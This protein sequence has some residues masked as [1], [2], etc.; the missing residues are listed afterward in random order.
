MMIGS[1]R[2]YRSANRRPHKWSFLKYV[3]KNLLFPSTLVLALSWYS[4]LD[5][6]WSSPISWSFDQGA[7]RW[8]W[9][10]CLFYFM[11]IFI[12]ITSLRER[13]LGTFLYFF[14]FFLIII[15][16][17]D[18]NFQYFYKMSYFFDCFSLKDIQISMVMH[19]IIKFE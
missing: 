15:S 19:S 10:S 3:I 5:H 2:S 16:Y 17:E 14:F 13:A 4:F 6:M 11:F 8:L 9:S 1:C 7:S 12:R 18:I